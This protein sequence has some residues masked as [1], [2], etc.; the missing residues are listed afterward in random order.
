MFYLV[1]FNSSMHWLSLILIYLWTYR[2]YLFWACKRWAAVLLQKVRMPPK[3][4]CFWDS[5][6]FLV[7]LEDLLLVLDRGL[8]CYHHLSLNTFCVP[9]SV[10]SYIAVCNHYSHLRRLLLLASRN[11]PEVPRLASSKDGTGNHVHLLHSLSFWVPGHLPNVRPYFHSQDPYTQG[12]FILVQ[13][14]LN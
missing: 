5:S 3:Q 12:S 10:L 8:H 13:I 6:W 14:Y 1:G 2:L 7:Q 4:K 11:A 9:A